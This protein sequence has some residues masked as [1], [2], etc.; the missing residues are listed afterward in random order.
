MREVLHSVPNFYS[1]NGFTAYKQV[2]GSRELV[3][4]C[5]TD[6]IRATALTLNDCDLGINCSSIF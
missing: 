6:M 3:R 1:D 4:I 2:I 5:H